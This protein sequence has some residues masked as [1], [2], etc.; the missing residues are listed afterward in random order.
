MLVKIENVVINT[1]NI[2]LITEDN[3]NVVLY[4]IEGYRKSVTLSVSLS[5]FIK[6]LE[7]VGVTIHG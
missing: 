1:R 2:T 3:G 4:F 5:K 7:D 6:H